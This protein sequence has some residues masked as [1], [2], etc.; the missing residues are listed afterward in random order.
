MFSLTGPRSSSVLPG[1]APAFF[2][3]AWPWSTP[4]PAI[5]G[6]CGWT[7]DDV[8]SSPGAAAMVRTLWRA[9]CAARRVHRAVERDNA[10]Q[11][12]LWWRQQGCPVACPLCGTGAACGCAAIH[13]RPA[14]DGWLPGGD[15][16]G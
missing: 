10:V 7:I 14:R 4:L 9:H 5:L 13:L 6:F 1:G 16:W 2:F 15:P 11:E 8:V 12:Q 3:E